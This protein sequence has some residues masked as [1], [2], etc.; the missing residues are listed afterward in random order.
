MRVLRSLLALCV[1]IAVSTSA[2][3]APV[4]PVEAD[5]IFTNGVVLPIRP[6]VETQALAI[7][8]G[9]VV[10][11]GSDKE[12]ARYKGPST[13]VVDL[14]GK[15]LMPGFVEPHTHIDLTA[16][17][18]SMVACGSEAPGGLPK[19]EATRRLKAAVKNLPAGA[20]LLGNGFDPSRTTPLWA[21]Y[22][23]QEL[24][25]IST[26]VPILVLN[27]SGHIAYVNHKAYALAGVTD[28]TPNP[29]SGRFGRDKKGHLD[30]RCYE[31]TSFAP[32][33][34]KAPR[35]PAEVMRAAFLKSLHLFSASG[36]TTVGDLNTGAALGVDAEIALLRSLANEAPVRVRS[37]LAYIALQGAKP[38]VKAFEGDDKLKFIGIKLTMDG[39]TQ[40]FTAALTQPYLHRHEKG[41]LDWPSLP[42]LIA[43]VKPYFDDGWQFAC[44]TNGDRALDQG[45]SLYEALTQKM[46]PKERANRR[47]RLEHFTVNRP[48]QVKKVADLGF[49]VSMTI[50]HVYFWG[51]VFEEYVLGAPRAARIDPAGDLHKAGVKVSFHSDCTITTVNP[52]RYIMTAVNRRPQQNPP[53]VLGRDQGLT[54][55]QALRAMTLDAA[56]QMFIDD[57]V[58]SLEPGKY[59][60]LV[61]LDQNPRKID[62]SKLTSIGIHA[63]YLAGKQV[64]P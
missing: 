9:L 25:A 7:R 38:P 49:T 11:V 59:A 57:K 44:H 10:A 12:I 18:L 60:D 34:A 36:V 8:G 64:R 39:S 35:A 56:W 22:S 50:G 5:V 13:K 4:T 42:K 15:T 30:G 40:G 51:K 14:K 62:P 32:F 43:S 61:V 55:D 2:W 6:A 23:V 41:P 17:N 52:L 37:Y 54:I 29:P 3:A 24:D 31:P 16:M 63:V 48:E 1:L 46:S 19:A 45:L 33:L 26:S 27:A 58:G 20:W 53:Q 47:L 28:K 21:D